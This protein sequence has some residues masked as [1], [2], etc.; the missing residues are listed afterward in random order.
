[1]PCTPT[2]TRSTWTVRK[3]ATANGP[4]SA[5]DGVRTPPVRMMAWS[6]RPPWYRTSAT[7]IEFVTTVILGVSTRRRARAWVVVPA[8]IAIAMPGS[9]SSAAAAAMASFSACWR[10][11]LVMNVGSASEPSERAVAPP[12][13]FTMKAP[14]VEDLQVATDRHVGDAQLTDQVRH[15][16]API[17]ADAL[18]DQG[19]ALAREHDVAAV[20]TR[21][22]LGLARHGDPFLPYDVWKD[23]PRM[24]ASQRT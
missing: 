18:H 5:S 13:T 10:P 22:N 24:P 21:R 4:T 14:I 16:H 3:A 6:G 1:M 20:Q 17:L 23:A 2:N 8:E 7:G 15:P 11:D 12:W 9:T 19:L